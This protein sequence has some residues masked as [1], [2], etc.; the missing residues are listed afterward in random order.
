[1]SPHSRVGAPLRGEAIDRAVAE[2]GHEI[3]RKLRT[4]QGS[5]E[6]HLR[7]PFERMLA[8]IGGSL[9]LA[10]TTIG[11]TR[12]PDL[13]IRPDFAVDVDGARVGYVELKRPG[14]G[15]PG[16][17]RS[18]SRRERDQWKGLKLLPNVLYADGSQFARFDFGVMKGRVGRLGP[19]LD[20]AGRGLHPLDGDFARTVTDFLLWKPTKPRSLGDLVKLVARL[21]R[22]L[23][24]DVAVELDREKTGRSRSQTF[25]G[26]AEDWRQVLFPQLTDG[27][28]CDQYAQTVT[29]ALLLARVEGVSFQRRAIG[30][31]ARLLGKKHS[32]MGRALTVLTDQPEEEHSVALTTMVRVLSVV[33]WSD[34]PGNSYAMLYED[35]LA[36]YDPILRRKSGVYYTPAGLVS[37]MVRFVDDLLR[38][39]LD[40]ALGFAE[41]D[42]IVVDPAMGTGSFLAEVVNQVAATVNR[43]EGL[44]AVVPHLRDLSNRLI[45]FEN[46]AAPYAVAEL[47]VHSLLKRRHRAE[48][49]ATERR[50]LADA[51]DDPDLQQL[52]MGRMYE[53]IAQSR[54][55][56]NQVK[57]AEPVM[58]VIGNPPYADKAKGSAPWIETPGPRVARPSLAA[59]RQPGNGRCEY[60]LSNKYIHFWRWATWKVFDAHP[61]H[62]AG[63]VA[64]VTSGAFTTGQGFAGMREYLRRTADEGWIIDLTPE[65]HQPP[66]SSRLFRGTQQPICVSVFIRRG[67]PRLDTPAK[68]HYV[69]AGGSAAEK[70]AALQGL[71]VTGPDWR[72][73]A[74]GWA[75]PFRPPSDSTWSAMPRITDL[76][77]MKVPGVKPN[78]TWVYAPERET[79]RRRWEQLLRAPAEEKPALLKETSFTRVGSD[80]AP[81]PGMPRHRGTLAAE[82]GRCPELRRLGHRF[83]DRKWVIADARLSDRPRPT[84]WGSYSGSQVFVVEQHAEPIGEGPALVFTSLI[85]DMHH[86]NGRGGRVFP[87]YRDAQANNPNVTPGLLGLLADTYGLAVT[88]A[89]LVAY[90]AAVAG[91]RGFARRFAVDLTTPGIRI[92]LTRDPV[93]WANAVVLG[94]EVLWLHTFGERCT[95][96]AAG[97]PPGPP[98][99]ASGRPAVR[100]SIPDAD[101]EMPEEITYV[102]KTRTLHIGAGQMAPVAL[103]VWSYQISGMFVVKHWFD[104]RKKKPAGVAG[105]PLNDVIATAWTPAMTTELLDVLNVLGRCVQMEP[106]QTALLDRIADQP[107]ITMEEL[108]KHRVLPVPTAA[109]GIPT[110]RSSND[111]FSNVE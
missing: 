101:G 82:T 81:V 53:A 54:R 76:M 30:E 39:R 50:F 46:Q 110:Q 1:M 45:G 35:F 29:F 36:E 57:R 103:E 56:A 73:C 25:S 16:T 92:P 37:F 22:L 90:L 78:R 91:H 52:P 24:E 58:V 28:F 13:S 106:R 67:E 27:Q 84:L 5:P 71:H 32:L 11:E 72:D 48:I 49:P 15:V 105:S 75:E 111:L 4:L 86:F 18:P 10:V 83:L 89:D 98:R 94:R 64:M 99:L 61:E 40:R 79:L 7:G 66:M 95:D 38:Y 31:I 43:E 8:A 70:I 104:Y 12:L 109:Q 69:A 55:G 68:I 80:V 77:P 3:G 47:R 26:L 87:L 34:Y 62:P 93:T 41:R 96:E 9:G 88:G 23:R 85:P 21:C 60:V 6:D 97:R 74:V 65:G 42:V 33:D 100:V 17:W 2:Y 20:K 63:I 59:F 107:L 19:E 14:H 44:G 102:E 51:L 108:R